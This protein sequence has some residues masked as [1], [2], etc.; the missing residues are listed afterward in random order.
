LTSIS[1]RKPQRVSG[2]RASGRTRSRG[3]IERQKRE[4]R[5]EIPRVLRETLFFIDHTDYCKAIL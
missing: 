1:A 4:A 3:E 5:R 2:Q